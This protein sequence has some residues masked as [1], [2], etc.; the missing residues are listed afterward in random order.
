MQRRR[1]RAP[2]GCERACTQERSEPVAAAPKVDHPKSR[3]NRPEPGPLVELAGKAAGELPYGPILS[4]GLRP[5]Q[6][7]FGSVNRWAV[8]PA[9]RAGL[10]PLFSTPLTGS[11]MLL[12][13][14]GRRSGLPREAPLGYVIRDGSIYCCAGFGRP[15]AWYRNLVADPRVE[16][17]LPT[18]AVAGLAETVTDPA[19]WSRIFPSYVRALGLIGRLVLGDVGAADDDRLASIRAMLPLVRI[20]PTGL[21]S[22]PADPGGGLWMVVQAVSL[23]LI[24]RWAIRAGGRVRAVRS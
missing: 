19:E 21:A 16:V 7:A 15:T 4:R 1:A 24:V 6:R 23:L 3:V 2:P 9:L 8:A 17:L 12:R 18:I 14:T 13:T 20:R 22:G 10:G 11:M 5:L